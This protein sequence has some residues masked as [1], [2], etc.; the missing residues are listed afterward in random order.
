MGSWITYI[1][2][3]KTYLRIMTKSH[4]HKIIIPQVPDRGGRTCELEAPPYEMP[5]F[6]QRRSSAHPQGQR[7]HNSK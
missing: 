7:Q 5:S 4:L 2:K 3:K 6:M 1:K